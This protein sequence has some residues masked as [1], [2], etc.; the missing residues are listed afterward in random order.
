MIE[1]NEKYINTKISKNKVNTEGY[2][3]HTRHF[4]KDRTIVKC[5]YLNS[6]NYGV[7]TCSEV[8]IPVEYVGKRFRIKLELVE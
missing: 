5:R 3:I 4:F 6:V 2:I 8:L 1:L 7:V